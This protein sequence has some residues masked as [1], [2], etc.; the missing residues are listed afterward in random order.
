ML[1]VE[2][3]SIFYI[4][5]SKKKEALAS[6]T[7]FLSYDGM[8]VAHIVMTGLGDQLTLLNVYNAFVTNGCKRQ[9]CLE[10]FLNVRS[11][12]K[13]KVGIHDFNINL[14]LEHSGPNQSVL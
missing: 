13:A 10:N 2:S 9:W 14:L 5:N 7:K 3:D 11:L 1:S 8:N 6:K 12:M 4:P